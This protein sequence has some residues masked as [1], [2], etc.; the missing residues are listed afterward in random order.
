M[1]DVDCEIPDLMIQKNKMKYIILCIV[2][3][4]GTD[5]NVGMNLP[6]KE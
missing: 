4:L 5:G 3:L 1:K 2:I 6:T